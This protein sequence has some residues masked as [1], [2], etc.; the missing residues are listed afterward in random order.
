MITTWND[1]TFQAGLSYKNTILTYNLS[2]EELHILC[3]NVNRLTN[4]Q[5]KIFTAKYYLDLYMVPHFLAFINFAKLIE[6]EKQS[7]F[8]WRAECADQS[9][10]I[11]RERFV[12]QEP[13]TY[14]FNCNNPASGLVQLVFNNKIF[15]NKDMLERILFQEMK[16]L[17]GDTHGMELQV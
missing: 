8:T 3:D 2:D 16:K 14:I 6:E 11:D 4:G 17:D 7:Y 12:L 9:I 1:V 15:E 10:V 5:L 13:L